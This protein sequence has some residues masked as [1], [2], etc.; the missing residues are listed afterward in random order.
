MRN[1]N[2]LSI[3]RDAAA[4]LVLSAALMLVAG[5]FSFAESAQPGAP[6][7]AVP[8]EAATVT[9]RDPV[10]LAK[11]LRWGYSAIGPANVVSVD[12]MTLTLKGALKDTEIDLKNKTLSV[13]NENKTVVSLTVLKKG[14]KIY[15]FRKGDR[16]VIR[17]LPEEE[18]KE[19]DE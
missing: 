13:M 16:V 9:T 8:D 1:S 4:A 2:Q 10:D 11:Y 5:A 15:V 17:L 6:A 18:E 12:S 3:L 14:S 19:A 7:V